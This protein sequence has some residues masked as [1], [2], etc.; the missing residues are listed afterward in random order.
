MKEIKLDSI[1]IDSNLSELVNMNFQDTC[2]FRSISAILTLQKYFKKY[3]FSS[4]IRMDAFQVGFSSE[5]YDLLNLNM[6]STETLEFFS[7]GCQ[8][9]RFEKTKRISEY[10]PTYRYLNV[11]TKSVNNC[12]VCDKCMRTQLTLEIIGKL[13]RYN[14][15]FN[16][17]KYNSKRSKYIAKILLTKNKDTLAMEIYEAIKEYGI[18]IPIISYLYLILMKI[19]RIINI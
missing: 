8:Y 18:K 19:K 12:S 13:E 15:V 14:S 3:Y 1:L 9:T 2:T 16:I 11:C 5:R 10:K 6:L 7:T 17:D 4:S